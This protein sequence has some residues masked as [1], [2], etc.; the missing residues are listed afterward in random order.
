MGKKPLH[1]TRT[2]LV[3]IASMLSLCSSSMLLSGAKP[4]QARMMLT[5]QPRCAN[6]AL[7]TGEPGGT[8]GALMKKLRTESTGWKRWKSA[9]PL[10]R[11]CEMQQRHPARKHVSHQQPLTSADNLCTML[12][13]LL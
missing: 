4:T 1:P 12:M 13:Q 8:S 5:R 3:F 7:T 6:R 9:A 2:Y 10:R 11:T